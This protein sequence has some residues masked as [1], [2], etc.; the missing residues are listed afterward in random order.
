M[1]NVKIFLLAAVILYFLGGL[2]F[3]AS[4]KINT[5]PIHICPP[6]I[7]NPESQECIS[8]KLTLQEEI[9][10]AFFGIALWLPALVGRGLAGN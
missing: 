2:W 3:Y 1:K 4:A 6:G 8:T 10:G 5:I 9:Y 7:L